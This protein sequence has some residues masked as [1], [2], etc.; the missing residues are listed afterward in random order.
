MTEKKRRHGARAI[1]E[2]G[3]REMAGLP[4]FRIAAVR[5]KVDTGARTSALHAV[6]LEVHEHSDYKTISFHVPLPGEPRDLRHTA[7]LLDRR[8]IKNTGGI[9]QDRYVVGT[10]LVL[11]H[12]HWHIE[13][14]LADRENMEFDLLLGRTALRSHRF[15]INPGRSFLLGA[16][17]VPGLEPRAET[18]PDVPLVLENASS[19]GA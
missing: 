6:D 15:L 8:P 12:R 1:T 7:R 18:G 2:I 16:P 13:L 9:P 11:G 4:D 19:H 17:N 10:T 14:S 3:W 5:A